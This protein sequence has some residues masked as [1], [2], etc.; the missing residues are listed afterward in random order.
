[1]ES[2][3]VWTLISLKAYLETKINALDR[4]LTLA[5]S[6]AKFA[7]EKAEEANE[8][9]LDLLNEFRAQSVEEQRKFLPRETYETFREEQISWRNRVESYMVANAAREETADKKQEQRIMS[10]GMFVGVISAG[11]GVLSLIVTLAIILLH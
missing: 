9:R 11:V 10:I 6:E 2:E 5:Q 4:I 3:P 7:V 1:M 8:R